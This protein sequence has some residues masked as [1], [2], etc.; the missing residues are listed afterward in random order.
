MEPVISQEKDITE[1]ERATIIR[2]TDI[3]NEQQPDC[4]AVDIQQKVYDEVNE[5]AD[6]LMKDPTVLGC[7]VHVLIMVAKADDRMGKGTLPC[8]CLVLA[9]P[10][11]P[12]M[13][14]VA[15][16]L[17]THQYVYALFMLLQ[18]LPTIIS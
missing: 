16:F 11:L 5:V 7:G 17:T 10:L 14:L 2:E 12:V 15:Y 6:K 18:V 8:G 1:A 13:D 3:L 9:H 4:Q